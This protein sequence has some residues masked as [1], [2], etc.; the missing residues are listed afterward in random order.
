MVYWTV[1]F[2]RPEQRGATMPVFDAMV[3]F[4]SGAIFLRGL[5]A[6]DSCDAVALALA[7]A[8][9][10]RCPGSDCN[11][12]QQVAMREVWPRGDPDAPSCPLFVPSGEKPLTPADRR[13]RWLAEVY[14]VP[15]DPGA[16]VIE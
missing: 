5:E 13:E 6:A 4:Q 2:R 10:R 9:R 1:G 8:R 16:T 11:P 7:E 14:G 12:V 15:P 3:R